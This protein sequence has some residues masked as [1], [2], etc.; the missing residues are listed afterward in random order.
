MDVPPHDLQCPICGRQ[1]DELLP[2]LEIPVDVK[3][4]Q[5]VQS[6]RLVWC[7]ACDAD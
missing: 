3:T 7:S 6:G 5:P 2:W 1:A 4:G